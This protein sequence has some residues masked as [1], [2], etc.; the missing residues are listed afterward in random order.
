V[1]RQGVLHYVRSQDAVIRLGRRSD[2][3]SQSETEQRPSPL[4]YFS[5]LYCGIST[6]GGT[7][8]KQRQALT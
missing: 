3:D 8:S 4:E 6:Q 2:L 1:R 5:K 7:I